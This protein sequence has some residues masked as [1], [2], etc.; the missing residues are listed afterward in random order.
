M[1]SSQDQNSEF[2]VAPYEEIIMKLFEQCAIEQYDLK[3]AQLILRFMQKYVKE[4]Y[5]KADLIR[6]HAD[7]K[8][9]NVNVDDINLAIEAHNENAFYK[10]LSMNTVEKIALRRNVNPIPHPKDYSGLI[11]HIPKDEYTLTKPNFHVYDEEIQMKLEDKF[12]RR[13]THSDPDYDSVAMRYGE[14][15]H[16]H[17]KRQATEQEMTDYGPSDMRRA[18]QSRQ[19]L[20]ERQNK[21]KQENDMM[22]DD[23]FFENKSQKFT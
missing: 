23:E 21:H 22:D 7:K 8:R 16:G 13:R 15:S 19:S 4:V 20:A 5:N 2:K 10:P 11:D 6:L 9:Q 18:N 3:A 12:T 14:E 17:Y 1:N